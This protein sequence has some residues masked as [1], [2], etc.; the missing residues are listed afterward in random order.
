MTN[1]GVCDWSYKIA[2][3]GSGRKEGYYLVNDVDPIKLSKTMYNLVSDQVIKLPQAMYNLV[4][5]QVIKLPQ[6]MYRI[7]IRSSRP[8]K[9][10]EDYVRCQQ[11]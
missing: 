1:R 10:V 5:D 2:T 7:D 9:I 6:A 8:Y 3:K 11:S 4:S